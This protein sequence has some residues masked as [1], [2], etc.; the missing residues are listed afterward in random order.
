MKEAT[1]ARLALGPDR[2]GTG[3]ADAATIAN[4]GIPGEARGPGI[5]TAVTGKPVATP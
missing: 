1:L 2:E 5:G 4:G 3:V